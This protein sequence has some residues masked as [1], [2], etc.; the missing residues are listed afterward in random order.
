MSWMNKP[1]KVID[2]QSGVMYQPSTFRIVNSKGYIVVDDIDYQIA[3]HICESVN[4]NMEDEVKES[5]KRLY[6]M[7]S[8]DDA[9]VWDCYKLNQNSKYEFKYSGNCSTDVYDYIQHD[10]GIID[11]L[12][13]RRCIEDDVD[14]SGT[15]AENTRCNYELLGENEIKYKAWRDK[16]VDELNGE[17]NE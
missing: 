5:V 3:K 16:I 17:N 7:I 15:L 11:G 14:V 12:L 1:W 8:S 4:K 9:W 2:V 6:L 13:D 10:I